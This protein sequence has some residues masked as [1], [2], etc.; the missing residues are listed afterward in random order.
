M[1]QLAISPEFN[2][3]LEKSFPPGSAEQALIDSLEKQGFVL[4][5]HCKSDPTINEASFHANGTGFLPYATIA[6]AYW[7]ADAE[8][9]IVWTK[10]FVRYSGL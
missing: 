1:K 3:R 5:G 6:A 7:Q 4:N 2:S 9:R 8:G 10:G